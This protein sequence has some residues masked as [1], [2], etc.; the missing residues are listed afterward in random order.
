MNRYDRGRRDTPHDAIYYW[1]NNKG[2]E[3]YVTTSFNTR[4]N[5]MGNV[6]SSYLTYKCIRPTMA[7]IFAAE[8]NDAGCFRPGFETFQS[9]FNYQNAYNLKRFLYWRDYNRYGV[10]KFIIEENLT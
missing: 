2:N 9:A 10:H 8:H 1:G 5:D 3:S 7:K 6:H 4:L